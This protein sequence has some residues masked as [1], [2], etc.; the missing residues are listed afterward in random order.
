[1]D[2]DFALLHEHAVTLAKQKRTLNEYSKIATTGCALLTEQGSIYTGISISIVCSIGF[3]AE[4][5]AM[6]EMLKN[7]E[8]RIMK[9]VSVAAGKGIRSPCGR[10]REFMR[11]INM[12]NFTTLIMLSEDRIVKLSDLLPDPFFK[13]M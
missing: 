7:N 9:L 13:Y 6:A 11:L 8:T 12:D 10:C 4:H 3:C 5:S 1:V 2:K